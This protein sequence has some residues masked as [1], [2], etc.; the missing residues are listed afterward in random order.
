VFPKGHELIVEAGYVKYTLGKIL[1][2]STLSALGYLANEEVVVLNSGKDSHT[3]LFYIQVLPKDTS[4]PGF[5]DGHGVTLFFKEEDHLKKSFLDL[6]V[7]RAIIPK[8]YRGFNNTPRV[9]I[10]A[11]H[12]VKVG[13]Y[14][15]TVEA[16]I[17]EIASLDDVSS[18]VTLGITE[19]RIAPGLFGKVTQVC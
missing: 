11:Y 16:H 13:Y 15:K 9:I 2:K 1:N 4:L 5:N 14:S 7:L 18:G 12:L 19:E 8:E 17:I 10:P 3:N 6:T